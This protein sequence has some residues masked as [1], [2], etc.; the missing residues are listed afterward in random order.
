MKSLRA[1]FC[2]PEETGQSFRALDITHR[3][4]DSTLELQ[5]LSSSCDLYCSAVA[6]KLK[7]GESVQPESFVSV[8]IFFSDIV[9]FTTIASKSEPLQIV[10]MLNKLYT[11]FD[12]IIEA[13][14]VYKVNGVHGC[15]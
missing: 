14:D 8:S 9:G 10:S 4:T 7:R 6:N 2:A 1:Q 12:E 15:H 5:L 11:I 13:Y 3:C